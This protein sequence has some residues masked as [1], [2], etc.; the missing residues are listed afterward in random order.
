LPAVTIIMI[1]TAGNGT[2]PRRTA[3]EDRRSVLTS[4]TNA[5][6]Y[7][8]FTLPHFNVTTDTLRPIK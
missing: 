6:R 5:H 2:P 7:K 1:A 8:L 3:T 4:R